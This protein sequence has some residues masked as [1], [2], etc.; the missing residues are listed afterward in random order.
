MAMARLDPAVSAALTAPGPHSNRM[1]DSFVRTPK[2]GMSGR[3]DC[4]SVGHLG[5]AHA[6]SGR[7]SRTRHRLHRA[8][9]AA[10]GDQRYSGPDPDSRNL[11]QA[12]HR[13]FESGHPKWGLREHL[14]WSDDE[15]AAPGHSVMKHKQQMS[16]IARRAQIRRAVAGR[17]DPASAQPAV[18]PVLRLVSSSSEA[19]RNQH[20]EHR[21]LTSAVE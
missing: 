4:A 9:L 20:D 12:S 7:R 19:E 6:R 5:K 10:V 8:A 15:S 17:K 18:R 3:P 2:W 13:P 1:S 14:R 21:E 16:L 11:I